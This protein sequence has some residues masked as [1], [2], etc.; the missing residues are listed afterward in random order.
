M[1]TLLVGFG[2][3]WTF[4]SELDRPQEQSWVA[5]LATLQGWDHI[6]MGTP[7][8]SIGHLT[9]QLF[10]FI[11]LNSDYQKMVFAV[12]LSGLTRYLSYNNA[13]KEFVN[14]T[15]EAVYSTSNIHQ[16]GR[17]PEC[18]DHMKQ[19]AQLTYRQVE[20]ANYNE[21]I[22]AQTIF[23]F[24]QACGISGIKCIF[25]SYFDL[26]E[27]VN[28]KHVVS[29]DTLYP[30]SITKALTGKEYALPD[31]RSNKY[32]EGKL[33]HPNMLGH[34]RIA[35]LLKEFYDQHYTRD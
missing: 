5:Q 17:P 20:D 29:T 28:Y 9:V 12:G 16:S 23:T 33:F 34:T 3:S 14:I 21:F 10:D 18:V 24:Q 30:T 26:P 25:F 13:G 6:N 4:G 27:F 2:D 11:K 8:S 31:I 35:E 1:D 19:L 32:F 15:P 22:T 7:A